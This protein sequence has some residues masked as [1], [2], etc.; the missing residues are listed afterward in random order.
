MPDRALGASMKC[1]GCQAWCT[2]APEDTPPPPRRPRSRAELDATPLA[3]DEPTPLAPPEDS[4]I[5][6]LDEPVRRTNSSSISSSPSLVLPDSVPPPLDGK[7]LNAGGI[8]VCVLA[9]AAGVIASFHATAFLTRPAA[10]VALIVGVM[11]VLLT[12]GSRPLAF[13]LPVLGT[14]ASAIILLLAFVSP[15]SLS[16]QY[17]ASR[18]PTT[19]NS[20]AV[21]FVA[22]SLDSGQQLATDGWA[23]ASKA[24]VQQGT[25]RVQVTGATLGPIDIEPRDTAKT[26][27]T[28][29][30]YL[31]ITVRLQHLGHE[32]PVTFIPWTGDAAIERNGRRSTA[33][34]LTPQIVAGQLRDPLQLHPGR[35]IGT[36]FVF[37]PSPNPESIRLEL[38]AETWGGRGMFRFSIPTTMV[39]T[40]SSPKSR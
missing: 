23:D 5:A 20:E 13:V 11:V 15:G 25:V 3:P 16:P 9:C 30:R 19:Y 34:D 32:G 1:P 38:P 27:L 37:E 22:L 17:E 40:R 36:V 24:A 29:E 26:R 2:A 8:L 33:L 10:G 18:Q 7:L 21:E 6:V 28:K 31:T 4:P 14:A 39:T 12:I 35:M